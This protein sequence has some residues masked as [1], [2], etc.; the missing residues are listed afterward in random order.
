MLDTGEPTPGG[1]SSA[2]RWFAVRALGDD[3]YLI[4]EPPY[5]NSYLVVGSERAALVDSGLGIANIREVAESL[6]DRPVTVVNT[7]HHFDHVGGNHLFQDI[8]IHEEG[9]EVLAQPTPSGVTRRFRAYMDQMM[10]HLDGY[11]RADERFFHL[12]TE[13]TTPRPLSEDIDAWTIVPS[14]PS[15]LLTEGD[16]VDLG[17]RALKV[18]HSP[19]HTADSICLLDEKRGLLFGGDTINSG[20]IYAHLPDSD[21]AAFARSTERLR[22]MVGSVRVVYVAH[23]GRYAMDPLFLHEVANGFD[24]LLQGGIRWRENVDSFGF[25][26]KQATFSRFSVFVSP[27]WRDPG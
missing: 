3:V 22:Q 20:P 16:Q 11:R 10:A 6:T 18:L 12:L 19:G 27:S 14:A 23:E 21:I 7:H 24:S 9:G 1:V 13:D 4:G 26:V 2:R 8:A 17:A 25:P 5:V 15:R